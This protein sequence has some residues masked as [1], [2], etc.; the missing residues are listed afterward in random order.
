M[1]A[2]FIDFKHYDRFKLHISEQKYSIAYALCSKH[3]SLTL[4]PEFKEMEDIFNKTFK[5]AREQMLMGQKDVASNT[6]SQY[7][8]I[9]SK[10]DE[11]KALLSGN[12]SYENSPKK[13]KVEIQSEKLL[14]AYEKVTSKS[15]TS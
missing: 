11:I 14:L 2:L 10:R 9:L 13:S 8:T 5:L 6:L 4:T 15:A 7:M 1:N 3:T 12:Y